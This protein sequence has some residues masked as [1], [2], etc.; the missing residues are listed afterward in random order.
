MLISKTLDDNQTFEESA[1]A[2]GTLIPIHIK[3]R[4][5]RASSGFGLFN[6]KQTKKP[7]ITTL[8]FI[9]K[10]F[11]RSVNCCFY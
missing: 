4:A 3:N 2:S 5:S 11:I 1:L 8:D 7:N 10:T 6:D 9:V